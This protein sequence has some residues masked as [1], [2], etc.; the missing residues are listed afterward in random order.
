M[1][2]KI[3][4]SERFGNNIFTR[5]TISSFFESVEKQKDKEIILDFSK[6]EF[7]SRSCADEYI[8]KKELSKKKILEVNLSKE[9]CEMFKAVE[10][11]YNEAGYSIS[12][13]FCPTNKKL[14][15]A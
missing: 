15:P 6:I 9:V 4:L 3:L 11:Q 1:T 7:I 5:N 10:N 12:F 2:N 8:K 13:S 14:I